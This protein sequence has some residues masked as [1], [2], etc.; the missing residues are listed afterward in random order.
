VN[1]QVKTAGRVDL[2]RLELINDAPGGNA[3]LGEAYQQDPEIARDYR[4]SVRALYRYTFWSVN[5]AS[6]R[7]NNALW[8]PQRK[9]VALALAYLSSQGVRGQRASGERES[10]LIKMPTG[11][12]KTGVI[13]TLAC[14]AR[15]IRRAIILTPRTALVEQMMMDLSWRFWERFGYCYL[16]SSLQKRERIDPTVLERLIGG[17]IK[18]VAELKDSGYKHIWET[19]QAERQI[20]VG[21]FNALH[22][23]LGLEPPAHRSMQGHKVRAPA[24][25]LTECKN[26]PTDL[27]GVDNFRALLRDSDLLI[28]DE[29]HYEP[30]YSWAQCVADLNVPTILFSATPYRNDYKYF[31]L[32]GNFCFNLGFDEAVDQRLIRRVQF[33]KDH[34]AAKPTRQRPRDTHRELSDFVAFVRERIQDYPHL[35]EGRPAKCIVHGATYETLQQLQREF[36]RQDNSLHAVLIHDAHAGDPKK[37]NGDLKKLGTAAANAL[38]PYR[39]RYVSDANDPNGPGPLSKIWLHQFK[40]L[41]GIDNADFRE[42]FLYDGFRSARELIQ[43][44]GRALRYSDTRRNVEESASIFGAK[45]PFDRKAGVASIAAV[46]YEQWRNYTHYEEYV[47]RTPERAFTAE[48]QLLSLLKKTAPDWQYIAGEFR[49]GFFTDDTAT[50]EEYVVPRRAVVCRYLDPTAV[51]SRRS[52]GA[53][54]SDAAFDKMARDC[55]KALELEDRFDIRIV[56]APSAG[57]DYKDI[58]LI[59]Y[60]A[61]ANSKLLHHQSIPE[62]RLGV[63]LIVRSHP[64]VF[65]LDTEGVCVD[66]ERLGLSSA[67]PEEMKRLFSDPELDGNKRPRK[68]RIRIIEVTAAGLDLSEAGIRSMTL[69]K[70][71][72][73]DSYFDLAEG[74]QAPSSLHGVALWVRRQRVGGC[75]SGAVD[76]PIQLPAMWT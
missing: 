47:A 23:V 16:D 76:S 8:A 41:E 56:P 67:S 26:D 15:H 18:S 72:L 43:Q 4:E 3:H 75:P 12:G 33:E 20:I 57:E 6:Y 69:R 68:D 19:R 13:A 10:A 71:N 70:R 9:A 35:P 40:L 44:V 46:S 64:F 25:V 62:W 32:Y 74:S 21:T 66:F 50:M 34:V 60:L 49:K 61:W 58:R 59:R 22:A 54:L 42:I 27:N 28:V 37:L 2:S 5:D 38:A 31:K 1:A 53:V 73:G 24:A 52:G 30:A 48:T 63:M 65:L 51:K 39:F 11:S 14:C 45:R 17:K 55:A 36:Y 7:P 29:G